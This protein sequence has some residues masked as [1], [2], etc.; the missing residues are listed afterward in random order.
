MY[1]RALT[2]AVLQNKE[3]R[4]R[5]ATRD[6]RPATRDAHLRLT[7]AGPRMYT[8][9]PCQEQSTEWTMTVV[10]RYCGFLGSPRDSYRAAADRPLAALSVPF[11]SHRS[12]GHRGHRV[13]LTT[14]PM[15]DTEKDGKS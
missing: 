12:V 7:W 6:A 1:T 8:S 3:S 14:W 15:V 9:V 2:P 10:Y 4:A 5:R 13:A 11:L